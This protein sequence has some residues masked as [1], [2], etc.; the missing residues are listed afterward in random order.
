MFFVGNGSKDIWVVD[1]G[2]PTYICNDKSKFQDINYDSFNIIIENGW[3]L[4]SDGYESVKIN[5]VISDNTS[6]TITLKMLYM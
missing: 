1:S 3:E 5:T 4:Y 2:S 6:K